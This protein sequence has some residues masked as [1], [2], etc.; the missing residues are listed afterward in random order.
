MSGRPIGEFTIHQPVHHHGWPVATSRHPQQAQLN[1]NLYDR[2][3]TQIAVRLA[4]S[5]PIRYAIEQSLLRNHEIFL[6]DAYRQPRPPA[7]QIWLG[8]IV[9]SLM[10]WA[11]LAFLLPA[12]IA[13]LRLLCLLVMQR[14][15]KRIAYYRAKGLCP[16]CGYDLRGLEF[17]ERCPECG[18]ILD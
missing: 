8:W 5:S 11:M 15:A 1:L 3:N 12:S 9:A 4:E 16:Q 2:P 7:E 17:N 6:R 10:L 14:R 18:A 13:M